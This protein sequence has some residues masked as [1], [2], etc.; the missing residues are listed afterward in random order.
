MSI[1]STVVHTWRSDYPQCE[2]QAKTK[3]EARAKIIKIHN[4]KAIRNLRKVS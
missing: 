1:N 4:I 2:V 3:K